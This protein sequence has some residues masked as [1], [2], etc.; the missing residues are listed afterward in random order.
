MVPMR[1]GVNLS[2]DIRFPEGDGPFPVILYRTPYN[3]A[4][5]LKDPRIS[6]WIREG[7]VF[8]AQD[9]RGRHESEGHF[10]PRI[11]EVE[12]GADMVAWIREQPFCNGQV[13]TTG[14]SYC[15]WTQLATAAAHP[16]G[17]VA[18][19]PQVMSTDAVESRDHFVG[20]T[21]MTAVWWAIL[22][23]NRSQMADPVGDWDRFLAQLPVNKLDE[24]L[25]FSAIPAFK[26][27]LDRDSMREHREALSVLSK[28][29][30]S[31]LPI[32]LSTGWYDVY[33]S[34]TV[35]D[36]S[37]LIAARKRRG[38]DT[39]RLIVGPW[40][41]G[42]CQS[43][44]LGDLNFGAGS[45]INLSGLQ[46]A[47]VRHYIRGTDLPEELRKAV[48]YFLMG[49]NE[50]RSA[51]QWPPAECDER[52]YYFDAI[53]GANSLTG[54]GRLSMKAP[55]GREKDEYT[56]NPLDPTPSIGGSGLFLHAPAGPMDQRPAERRD[57]VL[58]YTS[59]TFTEPLPIVGIPVAELQVSTSAVDTD[60]FVRI[61]D[62][63]PDGRSILIS[64]GGMRLAS[65][66]GEG[67]L[68][69]AVPGE[70]Y[71]LTIELGST[72]I[73][74]QPGHRLRVE[75]TSS[76]F[77]RFVRNLNSGKEPVEET[78]SDAVV[79]HQQL[80]HSPERPCRIILPIL[81]N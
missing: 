25:G 47:F 73:S 64:D 14:E 39:V 40:G 72:A 2:T 4:L 56:Y 70:V 22:N 9:C 80:F 46:N 28:L 44:Q 32:L 6:R 53:R 16:D 50:W 42:L 8:V 69:P 29:E 3:K 52:V 51:D 77:P 45:L 75:V 15:G 21:G 60:F 38:I 78:A 23:T 63:H 7:Y 10:L 27:A 74:L 20:Q 71:R 61:C 36:A 79:A 48:T 34:G 1:D 41:H 12:D 26:L 35:R 55:I 24:L 54:D 5:D 13:A 62:V 17:L 81:R 59:R 76:C 65:R 19:L 31:D 33:G 43:T 18:I 37:R 68:E 11:Q 58:C 30:K 67:T 57:D 66:G 49:A